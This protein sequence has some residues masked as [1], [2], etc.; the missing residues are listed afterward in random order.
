MKTIAQC[1][2]WLILFCWPFLITNPAL[3]ESVYVPGLSGIFNVRDFGAAGNGTT[4]DTS[5]ISSAISAA[6]KS[7]G[8]TVL[9]PPGIYLTGTFEL[10]SNITLELEPGAVIRGSSNRADYGSIADYGLAR[11]YGVSS[12]GEGTKVG[13]I[14]GRNV[15]NVAIIGRGT[16]DGSGDDFFDFTQPHYSLDFDPAATRQGA[17]SEDA[18]RQIGDGPVAEKP[19]GRPGT[20]IACFDCRNFLMR[21]ITLRNAPNWTVHL[22]NGEHAVVSGVHILNNPL[23]PNND[24]FDCFG[25]KDVHFSDCDIHTGDDDFAIVNSRDISIANCALSSRSSAIR[26]EAT[27]YSTFS[28]L[29]I[30]SNRGIAIYERGA[31]K[32]AHLVFSNIAIDTQLFGGHWWGKAEPIYIVAAKPAAP[33]EGVVSDVLFSNITGESESS[34][35]LYG[36]PDAPLRDITFSNVHFTLRATRK[37]ISDAVGGNFDFRWTATDR[38][39]AVF[40]HDIPGLYA[41]YADGIR[42]GDFS[43][44][45]DGENPGFFSSAIQLEDFRDFDLEGFEGRQAPNSAAPV[46]SLARGAGVTIR[47]SRAATGSNAF[48]FTSRV[49]G[50]GPFSGNDLS[51]ARSVFAG[52]PS[53]FKSYGN[54]LPVPKAKTTRR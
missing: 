3:A 23:L 45:W 21:D 50:E 39:Q 6:A 13:I 11:N 38:A 25:C 36:S 12:S 10:R 34:I 43:I 41:R 2:V 5:A 27:S 37:D 4:L 33:G 31:G 18:L 54:D 14:F 20:M 19:A 1:C 22:Q 32:T 40:K 30:H 8:G 7:G 46:I 51:Q 48:V 49:R 47:N 16:I 29:S 42:L 44:A 9:F 35:V 15:E 17:Q 52:D 53:H 24:G 26:L 28:G